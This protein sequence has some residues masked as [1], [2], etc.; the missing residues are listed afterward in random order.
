MHEFYFES[1]AMILTLITVGKMLEAYSK[2][3][4][5][6]SM[7][8][9]IKVYENTPT[10]AS[11]SLDDNTLYDELPEITKYPLAVDA[12]ADIVL[13]VMTSPE[14][15][16]DDYESWL[17]DV[18]KEFN[19]SNVTTDDGKTIG[20]QVRPV[21]SGLAADYI[22]SNKH[23]PQL[24]TPSNYLW[25]EYVNANGGNV[26]MYNERLVGNTA[27]LLIDKN[28]EYKTFAIAF[29]LREPLYLCEP[30][31]SLSNAVL[32]KMVIRHYAVCN[33]KHTS[34][35]HSIKPAQTLL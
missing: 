19:K 22:I 18:A 20:I 13:E 33:C 28:S 6:E 10:K 21:S 14:K 32:S 9:H 11:I 25:G 12:N 24:F 29:F 7:L 27:G 5:T 4:T 3:R 23:T 30:Y 34:L 35:E 1:A 26:T 8:K 16:G 2:G 15:A 31:E 17:I